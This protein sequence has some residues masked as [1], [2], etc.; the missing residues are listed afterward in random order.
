M[1]HLD[2][3]WFDS[4]VILVAENGAYYR[5]PSGSWQSLFKAT[6]DWMDRISNAINS[7]S[8]QFAGSFVERKNHSIVWH[9]RNVKEPIA[10]G[11]LTQILAA[12]RALNNS[13]QFTIRHNEFAIELST[14]G[15]DAGSF[16]ARW[17]GGQ[18]FDFILALGTVISETSVFPLLTDQAVTVRVGQSIDSRANYQV[19]K[20]EDAILFIKELFSERHVATSLDQGI[21]SITNRGPISQF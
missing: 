11:E 13:Q 14:N 4:P 20:R 21:T 2:K 7:L 19:S 15:I 8:F 9:Y 6:N 10:P 17:I 1:E 18:S 16:I 5:V 12:I 3:H